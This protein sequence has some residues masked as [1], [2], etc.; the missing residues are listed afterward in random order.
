VRT[1]P[2]A[3]LPS[4]RRSL[5]STGLLVLLVCSAPARAQDR[6]RPPALPREFRAAWVATVNNIDWP[7]RPGLPVAA[8]RA[9]LDEIVRRAVELKLNALVFQVRAAA[10]AFYASRLEPWSEWLTGVQGKAPADGFDPLAHVIE[11]SHRAGLQLHAWFNPYRAAHPAGKSPVAKQHVLAQMPD[12]CVRYGA[13]QWMDP[14]DELAAKWSLAVIQDVVRRYDVD[15]VHIDDYFYP[16]PEA[17]LPFP[18]QRSFTRYQQSGG[19]LGLGDWR[20]ANIDEFVRRMYEIVHA[21]KP[22]V[23]VGISPFGIAR[24]GVPKGIKAGI[25][26]YEQLYADVPKWLREGWLDY[27][28]PQLYWPIDQ[29]P[30]SFAA[31]L[32]WWHS[33]N[34]RKRHLWPGINPGRVLAG[35]PPSRAE[36]L[37]D[38]IALLRAADAASPGHVHF[39]F[40]ALRTDAPNVGGA[41]RDRVYGEPALAP[42]MPWLGA[43]PPRQPA[44]RLEPRDDQRRLRWD[45]D[46]LARFVVVQVRGARGWRT[47]AILGADVGVCAVPAGELAVTAVGRTGALSPPAV[48]R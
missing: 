38:Q 30:Q 23:Q 31:L 27:L 18:D 32:P 3:P 37:V 42:A 47:H 33:Q 5:L 45:P 19:E 48:A 14:G 26:Q 17:K 46:P 28:A 4:R 40:K 9:E 24:P 20:R 41:L 35:K 22:W 16:Y 25:D 13:Y 1:P 36:E 21:E 8:M 39:S 11:Q 29:A 15:G 7:S 12:A 44:V 2:P 43:E 10:D 34:T 6:S